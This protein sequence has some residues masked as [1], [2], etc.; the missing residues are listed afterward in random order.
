MRALTGS[1]LLALALIPIWGCPLE[2]LPVYLAT[3][4]PGPLT[5][6]LAAPAAFS[7]QDSP[8]Q[9]VVPG[10]DG[11]GLDMLEGCW[12]RYD[13]FGAPDVTEESWAVRRIDLTRG[14]MTESFA[15]RA[16]SEG[17]DQTILIVNSGPVSASGMHRFRWSIKRL[18]Y[19]VIQDDG[20]VAPSLQ[21]QVAAEFNLGVNTEW[22]FTVEGD[23]LKAVEVEP[24]ATTFEF[25]VEQDAGT[26]WRRLDCVDD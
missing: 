22:V 24:G 25:D 16:P 5:E 20:T 4:V 23:F 9:D 8:L 21:A 2:P 19:G 1:C 18:E 15:F 6:V 13:L 11:D 7:E 3:S 10:D 14:E 26:M 12:G 17:I